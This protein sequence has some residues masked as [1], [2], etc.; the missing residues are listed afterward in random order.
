MYMA[1]SY[2]GLYGA[3]RVMIALREVEVNGGKGR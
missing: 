2:A 1:D 3:T